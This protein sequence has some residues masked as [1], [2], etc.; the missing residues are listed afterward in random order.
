MAHVL[1][2]TA[3]AMVAPTPGVHRSCGLC[4]RCTCSLRPDPAPKLSIV[5]SLA[6]S[7]KLLGVSANVLLDNNSNRAVIHLRG[8]PLGGSIIGF[9]RFK[10]EGEGVEMDDYMHRQLERRGIEIENVGAYEDLSYL[11]IRIKL[12][13]LGTH[14]MILPR[15]KLNN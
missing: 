6:Y 5:E 13:L 3:A 7:G 11:W 10:P 1:L 2:L 4:S 15:K 9:A 14:R 12:P 8:V